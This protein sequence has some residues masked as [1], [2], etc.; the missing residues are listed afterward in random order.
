MRQR[1]LFWLTI[2][3]LSRVSF[4]PRK[5]GGWSCRSQ[6]LFNHSNCQEPTEVYGS[7]PY[8]SPDVWGDMLEDGENT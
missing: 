2:D 4:C 3:K 7:S 6:G 8:G 5:R 1:K